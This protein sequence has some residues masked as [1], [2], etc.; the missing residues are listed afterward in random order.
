MEKGRRKQKDKEKEEGKKRKKEGK[1]KENLPLTSHCSHQ[2][3][4]SNPGRSK[5]P[6]KEIFPNRKL[7]LEGVIWKWNGLKAG[8][9]FQSAS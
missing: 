4:G 1:I 3:A 6:Q 5:S 9:K 2:R 8:L 7:G